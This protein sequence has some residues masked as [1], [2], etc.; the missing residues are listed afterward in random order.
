M[1]A[2]LD[3][4][5]QAKSDHID[6][7]LADFVI[8][9]NFKGNNLILQFNNIFDEVYYNHLSRIKSINPEPG[10]NFHLIYKLTM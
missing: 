2:Q 4:A 9:Y 5:T 6:A 7:F 10:K 3:D 8:S 1:Q